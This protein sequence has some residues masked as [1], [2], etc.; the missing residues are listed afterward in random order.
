M[1]AVDVTFENVQECMNVF[2]EMHGEVDKA[3][4]AISFENVLRTEEIKKE[5]QTLTK[6]ACPFI[7]SHQEEINFHG[8]Q[9]PVTILLQSSVKEDFVLFISLGFGVNLCFQLPSFTFVC[10]FKKKCEKRKIGKPIA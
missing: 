8:F 9:D 4:A 10:L 1:Q 7:C 5:Q 2:F 6:E 3:I